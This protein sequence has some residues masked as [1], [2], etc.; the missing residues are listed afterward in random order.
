[1]YFFLNSI[2]RHLTWVMEKSD[3]VGGVWITVNS[4]PPLRA[5]E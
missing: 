3:F 1:M 5:G 2:I 4:Q